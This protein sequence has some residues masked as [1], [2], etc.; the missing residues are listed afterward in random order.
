M[1]HCCGPNYRAGDILA[2]VTDG[3]FSTDPAV[4]TF[5]LMSAQPQ[6]RLLDGVILEKGCQDRLVRSPIKG[7]DDPGWW[8][9]VFA[10][11]TIHWSPPAQKVIARWLSH[12]ALW[13]QH[14]APYPRTGSEALIHL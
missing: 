11:D 14:N 4:V 12:D 7:P 5:G 10:S 1:R 6:K 8:I 13:T 2:N 3:S 9:V